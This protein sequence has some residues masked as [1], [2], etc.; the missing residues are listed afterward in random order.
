[1][2]QKPMQDKMGSLCIM[3]VSF[4]S[5]YGFV[6]LVTNLLFGDKIQHEISH[7]LDIL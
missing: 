1:M 2:L 6:L 4:L 7:V 3:P 5:R